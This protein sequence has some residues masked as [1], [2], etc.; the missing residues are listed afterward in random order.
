MRFASKT[1]MTPKVHQEPKCL[2]MVSITP[3]GFDCK[4]LHPWR[5]P[6]AR[7]GG[8]KPHRGINTLRNTATPR[9]VTVKIQYS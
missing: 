4:I 6:P 1:K 9:F 7:A 3:A 8:V 5:Q 2:R